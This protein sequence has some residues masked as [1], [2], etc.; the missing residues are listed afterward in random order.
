MLVMADNS[1]KRDEILR[2]MLKTPPTPHKPI[3][4][5]PK[6]AAPKEADGALELGIH[7]VKPQKMSKLLRGKLE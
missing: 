4:K 1:E 6:R 3:G 2:R 5:K 7:D